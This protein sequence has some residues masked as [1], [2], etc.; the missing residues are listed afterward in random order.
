MWPV[1]AQ[2]GD[3]H[4][5]D[6]S[7][8]SAG[9]HGAGHLLCAHLFSTQGTSPL[10]CVCVH[11]CV[12]VCVCVERLKQSLSIQCVRVRV[13]VERLK[14]SLADLISVLEYQLHYSG[15]GRSGER[16][17]ALFWESERGALLFSHK[18]NESRNH[19]ALLGLLLYSSP[20]LN[21]QLGFVNLSIIVM[22][23]IVL[24]HG[25]D[26]CAYI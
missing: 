18:W 16:G 19:S 3:G 4:L 23:I 17:V 2:S 22:M 6:D 21:Q 5:R 13:C 20:V 26:K 11:V 7:G 14:Q 10:V 24:L 15:T 25:P 1:L 9:H 12:C 8:H